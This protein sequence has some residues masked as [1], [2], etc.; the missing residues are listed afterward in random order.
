[1]NFVFLGYG[2]TGGHPEHAGGGDVNTCCFDGHVCACWG[3]FCE[4]QPG[5]SCVRERCVNI[6]CA[7]QM[8]A[9]FVVA[10]EFRKEVKAVL[11]FY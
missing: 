1:M 8:C 2:G 3:R 9:V 10:K 4:N 5:V 7:S 11:Y 6:V